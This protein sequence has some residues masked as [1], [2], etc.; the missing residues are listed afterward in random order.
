MNIII[1]VAI[2]AV[3]GVPLF[4]WWDSKSRSGTKVL[5]QWSRFI[6][7][8]EINVITKKKIFGFN[9]FNKKLNVE[10][11]KLPKVMGGYIIE[12][13]NPDDMEATNQTYPKVHLVQIGENI[14]IPKKRED[15]LIKWEESHKNVDKAVLMNENHAGDTDIPKAKYFSAAREYLAD[16][17]VQGWATMMTKYNNE[18]HAE[19]KKGFDKFAPYIIPTF[20]I[21]AAVFI[22]FFAINKSGDIMADANGEIKQTT[23][24]LASLVDT[25][26]KNQ[27]E[28]NQQQPTDAARPPAAA[29]DS[30]GGTS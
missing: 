24:K 15:V 10:E 29:Q 23:G 21:I 16:K 19:K 6:D 9:R 22:I 3:I 26:I 14:F 5:I 8:R 20:A 12:G 30:G 27:N 18:F 13:L 4:I 17:D 28:N 1:W 25:F 7:D 11:F 2:F